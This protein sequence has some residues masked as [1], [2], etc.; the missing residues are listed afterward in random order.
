MRLKTLP[1]PL[2]KPKQRKDGIVNTFIDEGEQNNCGLS[3]M[4]YSDYLIIFKINV[5]HAAKTKMVR[6]CNYFDTLEPVVFFL[7]LPLSHN[8]WA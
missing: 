1:C 2:P 7:T 3:P 6:K 4:S 5:K 8:K